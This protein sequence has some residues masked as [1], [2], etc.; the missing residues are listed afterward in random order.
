M[1]RRQSRLRQETLLD[2]N[3]VAT[4][5]YARAI[6]L[7]QP[8]VLRCDGAVVQGPSTSVPCLKPEHGRFC[9]AADAALE[10]RGVQE[11]LCL[12]ERAR[13]GRPG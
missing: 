10:W 4:D 3:T 1:R 6:H 11:W 8:L 9:F 5:Y 7:N 2:S 12:V 13:I